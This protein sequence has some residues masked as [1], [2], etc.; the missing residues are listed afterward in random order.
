M[1]GGVHGWDDAVGIV[2]AT[3][4]VAA[5]GRAVVH[6][7]AG[8]AEGVP[9]HDGDLVLGHVAVRRR[10]RRAA[11]VSAAQAA[12]PAPDAGIRQAGLV[13]EARGGCQRDGIVVIVGRQGRI[14]G[15]ERLHLGSPR[16]HG[17]CFASLL[18]CVC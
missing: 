3:A 13:F 17:V 2:V 9:H 15:C 7:P 1:L 8:L 6:G 5:S 11:A 14:G 16:R 10:R 12:D 18:Y 4:A